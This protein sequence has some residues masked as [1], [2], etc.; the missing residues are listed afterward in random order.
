MDPALAE[1]QARA[2]AAKLARLPVFTA[3]LA[4]PAELWGLAIHQVEL[5]Q[6]TLVA[7]SVDDGVAHPVFRRTV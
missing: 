5:Q 6:F 1:V 4:M 2:E 7:W 3:A